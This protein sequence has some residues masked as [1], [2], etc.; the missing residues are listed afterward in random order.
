MRRATADSMGSSLPA[1]PA[2]AARHGTEGLQDGGALT[3]PAPRGPGSDLS[4]HAVS[5]DRTFTRGRRS[6]RAPRLRRVSLPLRLTVACASTESEAFQ[7]REKVPPGRHPAGDGPHIWGQGQS[8]AGRGRQWEEG[9]PGA[10]LP[11]TRGRCA[12]TTE[13]DT[14]PVIIST[15]DRERAATRPPIPGAEAAFQCQLLS[16][17]RLPRRPASS[18]TSRSS[19]KPGEPQRVST[20]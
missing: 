15:P 12:P 1:W 4:P 18:G 8:E 7:R 11:A 3:P 20:S 2:S 6:Y 17:V 5:R 10:A 14:H 16:W 13:A 9:P 19:Q